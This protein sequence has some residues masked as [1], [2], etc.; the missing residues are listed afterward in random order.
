MFEMIGLLSVAGSCYSGKRF[1]DCMKLMYVIVASRRGMFGNTMRNFEVSALPYGNRLSASQRFE[2][3]LN[4]DQLTTRYKTTEPFEIPKVYMIGD[5]DISN[6]IPLMEKELANEVSYSEK[7]IIPS[8]ESHICDTIKRREIPGPSDGA[9]VIAGWF[10]GTRFDPE[11]VYLFHNPKGYEEAHSV[12]N[13]VYYF[14]WLS[15]GSII[16]YICFS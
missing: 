9:I 12:I 1:V 15:L 3:H 7:V 14:A 8:S 16:S 13:S 6:L 11:S 5:I 10:N 2:V 4:G